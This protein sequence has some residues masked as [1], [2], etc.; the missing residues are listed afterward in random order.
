MKSGFFSAISVLLLWSSA[1]AITSTNACLQGKA[2]NSEFEQVIHS[3]KTAPD[4]LL[5]LFTA[6]TDRAREEQYWTH[7]GRNPL[8]FL[9]DTHASHTNCGLTHNRLSDY[10]KITHAIEIPKIKRECIAASVQRRIP[11]G[12]NYCDGDGDRSP[13]KY[14]QNLNGQCITDEIVSYYQWAIR[15]AYACIS[16][17]ADGPLD[18]KLI[19]RIYNNE[20]GFTPF[21]KGN[22]GMGIGQLTTSAVSDMAQEKKPGILDRVMS[23]DRPECRPFQA[24]LRAGKPTSTSE[25]CQFQNPNNGIARQLIYT[26]GYLVRIRD[27]L[28]NMPEKL[29]A[30]GIEDIRFANLIL[31]IKYSAEAAIAPKLLTHLLQNPKM[32]YAAF[33]KY[34]EDETHYADNMKKTFEDLRQHDPS[35]KSVE[36]CIEY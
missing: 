5:G 29:K 2:G 32:S 21:Q 6:A 13:L 7:L 8:P 24:A 33:A 4:S 3:R 31:A 9:E 1:Q 11:G 12:N 18:M 25:I 28:M 22:A 23:S 14:T 27:G 26:M 30:K 20:S 35:I 19:F 17:E 15:Q 16:Y 34:V 36:D 10:Q